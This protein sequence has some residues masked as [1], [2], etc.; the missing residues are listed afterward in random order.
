MRLSNLIS[1]WNSQSLARQ[2]LTIGGVVSVCAMV[3]IG[4]FLSNRIQEAVTSNA[5][6]TTALYV[7]SVIAPILPDMQRNHVLDDTT[8][9]A[10]D[11]TLGQGALG[12][13]LLLFRLWRSDGTVLYANDPS[14]TGTWHPLDDA[15]QSAFSGRMNAQFE[16][17]SDAG[18]REGPAVPVLKIYNPVL[19]PWSGEVVA[20]SEFHEVAGEFQ[21]SLWQARLHTWLAVAAFTFSFFVLLSVIVLRGSRTIEHQR[22]ALKQRVNELSE[23]LSQNEVLRDRVQRASQRATAFNESYLRR[24]GADLHDGPAQ[25]VAYA[26]LRLDGAALR[27]PSTP[28]AA[29]E[30]EI[31]A[32]RQSLD[33]AMREIRTICGGLVLP[34]IET[35][36]ISDLL[37]QSVQVHR[38]R[39]GS[40]VELSLSAL[41]PQVSLATKICIYRF[42]QETLNNAFRHGG[43][44]GQRVA[45]R[46]KGHLLVIEVADRG[47][48]FEPDD[49]RP[50]SLGL[51][52]LRERIESLGGTF[53]IKTSAEG[54]V[55]RMTASIEET[56]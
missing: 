20:V 9:R 13:R 52:G 24:I 8:A 25:L 3:L 10:L 21:Q 44:L 45:Q 33:E 12:N 7:D 14:M 28:D 49:V 16:T 17:S 39:T 31:D 40:D 46:T 47:P 53:E 6:A 38:Q 54:T 51:A 22:H 5:A 11:E 32:I 29:R 27:N 37:Q 48:G 34:Q 55:V 1:H 23:L 15:L 30:Q 36:G 35:A 42:V 18:D 56:R 19:Q 2:F 41:P 43:G 26:S 4:A 50:T